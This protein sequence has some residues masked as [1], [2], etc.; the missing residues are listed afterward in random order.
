MDFEQMKKIVDGAPSYA[1]SVVVSK[2]GNYA[3]YGRGNQ[4]GSRIMLDDLRNQLTKREPMELRAVDIPHGTIVL[5][6]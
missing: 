2:C 1:T 3:L 5:E 6:K 4:S